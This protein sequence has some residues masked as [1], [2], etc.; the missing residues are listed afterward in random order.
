M[1]VDE[2][3]TVISPELKQLM[4][5]GFTDIEFLETLLLSN[6]NDVHRTIQQL[7]K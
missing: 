1:K 5:M 7:L 6:G 2:P 3:K 4:E